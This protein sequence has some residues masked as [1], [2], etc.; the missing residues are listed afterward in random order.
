[1][2]VVGVPLVALTQPF[3][4]S[5]P[6]GIVLALVLIGLGIGFWR[7]ATSLHG[8]ARAGAEVIVAALAQQMAASEEPER[9]QQAMERV[10]AVLPGLG[11]PVP[12]RVP[13]G[14]IVDGRT[15]AQLNLRG[16]TGA[17]VLAVL[18]DGEQVLVP[19]GRE[20]VRAGDVLAIAG[21][22]EAIEAARAM[23]QASVPAPERADTSIEHEPRDLAAAADVAGGAE[24]R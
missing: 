13:P 7:S 11:E 23:V 21:T 5:F 3:L 19:A 8:H 2:F 9:L 4:P 16:V 17:T 22:R 12:L 20:V 6:L 24:P 1:V 10:R 15:L 18:R 14:S